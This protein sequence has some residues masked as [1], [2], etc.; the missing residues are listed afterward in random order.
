M[1]GSNRF[2]SKLLIKVNEIKNKTT[3]TT[4]FWKIKMLFLFL[5]FI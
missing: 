2:L 5:F 3:L 1:K 4:R